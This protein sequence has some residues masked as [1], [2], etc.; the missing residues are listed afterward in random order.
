MYAFVVVVGAESSLSLDSYF[1]IVHCSLIFDV[2]R[3]LLDVF[4]ELTI[5]LILLCLQ[6]SG[7]HLRKDDPSALKG[8]IELVFERANSGLVLFCFFICF[9]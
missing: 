5:E 7:I 3:V 2:I 6:G 8:I 1:Q 9:F 4:S